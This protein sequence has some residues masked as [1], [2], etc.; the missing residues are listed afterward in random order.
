MFMSSSFGRVVK[1]KLKE[2][3]KVVP[4]HGSVY[5]RKFQKSKV[6][7]FLDHAIEVSCAYRLEIKRPQRYDTIK[8]P[9]SNYGKF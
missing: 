8:N 7:Y 4:L 9:S 2:C 6:W 1:E 5:I 3:G